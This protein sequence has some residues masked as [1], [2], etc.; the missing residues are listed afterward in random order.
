MHIALIEV[1]HG[2]V[3]SE[4]DRLGE[5]HF[6]DTQTVPT[7][8]G[9]AVLFVAGDAP[10]VSEKEILAN[11][12][13]QVGRTRDPMGAARAALPPSQHVAIMNLDGKLLRV[14]LSRKMFT[15]EQART[16]TIAVAR[17]ARQP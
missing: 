12:R 2:S 17:R 1:V 15:P 16:Y 8:L 5:K 10:E 13:R 7:A 14:S 4:E 6:V 9:D 11:V 3:D